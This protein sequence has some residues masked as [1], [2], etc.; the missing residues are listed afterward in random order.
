VR[1][2]TLVELMVAMTIGLALTVVIAQL[3]L[4]S[5]AAFNSTDSLSRLQENARYAMTL[6]ACESRSARL[7]S[8]PRNWQTPQ[9]I[10][11]STAPAITGTD[12]GVVSSSGV[13]DSITVRYQGSGTGTGTPDMTVQDCVGAGVDY[14]ATVVNTFQILNDT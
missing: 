4:G 2:M 9:I 3:F 7:L 5:K 13:P 12:G 1:G 8:D 10:F 14:N 6:L 11:P